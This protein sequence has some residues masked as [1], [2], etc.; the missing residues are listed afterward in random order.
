MTTETVPPT[1][2][3][4]RIRSDGTVQAAADGEKV[5]TVIRHARHLEQ[6]R[7]FILPARGGSGIGSYGLYLE[8][9]N[10][11]EGHE[12]HMRYFAVGP[13]LY[14]SSRA[15]GMT[16]ANWRHRKV[17]SLEKVLTFLDEVLTRPNVKLLGR[18]L[19]VELEA[20]SVSQVE[21]GQM[22]AAR[23]RGQYRTEKDYGKYE[24]GDPVTSVPLPPDF[25]ATF[26]I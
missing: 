6:F 3:A 13:N 20:D 15:K 16:K 12:S 14:A 1:P 5:A 21:A 7:D 18:P 19:L 10:E 26:H 8:I 9:V 2:V 11:T 23:F 4:T 22:P 24:F 25:A 17:D